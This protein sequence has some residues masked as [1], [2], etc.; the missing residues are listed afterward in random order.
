MALQLPFVGVWMRF[1]LF[2]TADAEEF[3]YPVAARLREVYGVDSVDRGRLDLFEGA[4]NIKHRQY[5]AQ[6]LLDYLIRSMTSE[7]ALWIVDE[8]IYYD[9]LSFVMGLAMYHLA[10]VVSTYRLGSAEMVAKECIHE[11]GHVL[12]L[13]HCKNHCVMRFSSSIKDAEQKPA[14]LCERCRDIFN[15]KVIEPGP[16]L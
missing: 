9:H 11:A 15:R 4:Y 8:D 14:S 16:L 12:G 5:D 13:D 10:G 1:D 7:H 3:K 2:Y 6:G